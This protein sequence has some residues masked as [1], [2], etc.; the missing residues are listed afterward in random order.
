MKPMDEAI[1]S[2]P[3]PADKPRGDGRLSTSFRCA[4]A[5]IAHVLRSQRNARI[6]LGVTLAIVL[7][8]W[9]LRLTYTEWAIIALTVAVVLVAEMLNTAIEATIDLTTKR[10]HPL[11]KVAKDVAAGAVLTAAIIA[12]IV[13]LLILGPHLIPRVI[14]LVR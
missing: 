8:G 5:G 9:W 14:T 1:S 2:P 6:H 11:A 13:G 3:Q 4:F 10:Y 12:V 7:L